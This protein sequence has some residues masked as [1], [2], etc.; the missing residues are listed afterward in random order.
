[1]KCE[2]NLFGFMRNNTVYAIIALFFIQA[3]SASLAVIPDQNDADLFLQKSS[4]TS[5]RNNSTG[6]NN[7][8]CGH[9]VNITGVMAYPP[10]W[11]I[12][13]NESIPTTMYVQCGIWNATMMLDYWIYD[14]NNNTVDSG[15]YSWKGTPSILELNWTASGQNAGNYNFH[16]DL[17]VNGILVDSDDRG[18]I[19]VDTGGGSDNSSNPCLVVT[20]VTMNQT[21]YVSV[22]LVNICITSIMYPGI[23]A[24]SN[25]S[26][27]WGLH[28]MWWYGMGGN[29]TP[30]Q[31]GWQLMLN[32]SVQNGTIVTIHFEATILNCGPGNSWSHDCPDGYNNLAFTVLNNSTFDHTA[33]NQSDSD[34]DGYLDWCEQ[35]WGYD[36]LNQTS[37]PTQNETCIG[38]GSMDANATDE[39][40]EPNGCVCTEQ[41]DPV[42]GSDG[43]TYSNSCYAECADVNFT[44]GECQG[45]ST[46]D[47]CADIQC[48][49]CPLGMV[50]DP[51][52]GCCACMEAPGGNN[53]DG[54]NTS[55]NNTDGNTTGGNNTTE[56]TPWNN[57]DCNDEFGCSAGER[58]PV[59]AIDEATGEVMLD[60]DG[61][62]I[63]VWDCSET[64][65]VEEEEE[66]SQIPSIG[67]LGTFAAICVGFVAVISREQKE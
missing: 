65:S 19:I 6:G 11:T 37:F 51:D 8:G 45:N 43:E 26:G 21:Y 27:V 22:D 33:G 64:A 18:F 66:P 53:T 31:T 36:P 29:N 39:G 15:N 67:V 42:C 5:A 1:M 4:D 20:N 23:N 47:D 17:Y 57:V 34:G 10:Y 35:H 30:I 52:G 63:E 12:G 38:G 40:G 56:C 41:W 9:D 60:S 16:A 58:I 62:Q 28:D 7:T 59:L 54:N 13:D 32:E 2:M 14:E 55:G 49:A 46:V 50:S 61:N 48:D 3:F 25:N 44:D 24:T